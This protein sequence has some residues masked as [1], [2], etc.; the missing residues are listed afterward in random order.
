M[1]T[2]LRTYLT[3]NNSL[4]L[5]VQLGLY[6]PIEVIW[7]Q[8]N[9]SDNASL[10]KVSA[11]IQALIIKNLYLD[12][13]MADD[14]KTIK[15]DASDDKVEIE[16]DLM[17]ELV[18]RPVAIKGKKFNTEINSKTAMDEVVANIGSNLNF[19]I[20]ANQTRSEVNR[21]R[22]P[23]TTS[24]LQQA[25]SSALGYG[26]KITM[27]LAQKLYEGV[28]V[29]GQNLGLITYMRTDSLTL[30]ADA[31]SQSRQWIKSKH[32]YFLPKEPR[33]YKNKSKNAQEAHEA[34]RPTNP[35]LDPA[36]LRAKLEPRMWKLYELIWRQTIASQMTDEQRERLS[37]DMVNSD[38]TK[39]AGSTAWTTSLG[40]KVLYPNQTRQTQEDSF[41]NQIK[42]VWLAELTV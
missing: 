11:K 32:P 9:P 27:Q 14:D 36:S 12:Q 3:N 1:M 7:Q 19:Q 38:K 23:F 6:Q 29:D 41:T 18:L 17:Q 39:F 26:P 31:L 13:K 16:L 15:E 4:E 28:D 42:K 5:V 40:W 24:T 25:A 2:S 35:L 34:I 21:P 30:S 10:E 22:P 20:E 8:I 33:V 37:F